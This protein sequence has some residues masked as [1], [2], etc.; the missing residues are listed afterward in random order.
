MNINDLNANRSAFATIRGVLVLIVVIMGVGYIGLVYY[1]NNELKKQHS[2]VFLLEASGNIASAVSHDISPED[3]DVMIKDHVSDFYRLFFAFDQFNFAQN[4]EKAL[5]LV[6]NSGK[7]L[8][9][10]YKRDNVERELK[11]S[12]SV[13]SVV[14][15]EVAVDVTTFPW[16]A[17]VK[18]VQESRSGNRVSKRR[19]DS[20]VFS[21]KKVSRS[22]ENPHGLMI[23]GFQVIN[24]EVIQ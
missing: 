20:N 1:F 18:A 8:M 22:V 9:K 19:M 2:R 16:Q 5:N 11:A 7:E 23:E 12:N 13:I 10:D 17:Q 15:E 3:L 21:V 24:T 14:V 4:T 6:G